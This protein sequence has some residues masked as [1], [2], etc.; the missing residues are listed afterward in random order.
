MGLNY[1]LKHLLFRPSDISVV[2]GG[3]ITKGDKDFS[4]A[5]VKVAH[6]KPMPTKEK[7][8]QKGAHGQPNIHLMQP[9]KQ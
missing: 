4:P 9:G 2:V 7:P 1:K 5:A 3:V 8:H 6:E